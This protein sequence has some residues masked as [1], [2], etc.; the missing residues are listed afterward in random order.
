MVKTLSLSAMFFMSL[1]VMFAAY[2]FVPA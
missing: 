1:A 2:A